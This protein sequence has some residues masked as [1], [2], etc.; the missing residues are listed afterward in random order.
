MKQL[1]KK[2][3]IVFIS[4]LMIV[5]AVPISVYAANYSVNYWEHSEP[6]RTLS[7]SGGSMM[8]GDDVRWYQCAMNSLII[9]GDV[10]NSYLNASKLNVDGYFGAASRTALIAFQTKY[11]LTVDGYFG[12]NSRNKIKGLLKPAP[13]TPSTPSSSVPKY[14]AVPKTIDEGIYYIRN[15]HSN[16]YLD[17]SGAGSSNNTKLIQHSFNGGRNQRFRIKYESTGFYKIIPMHS[18]DKCLDMQSQEAAN[19]NGTALQIYTSSNSYMEQN[20]RINVLSDG[21]VEIGS[22]VSYGNKVLEVVNS[23]CDN[24]ATVQLWEKSA[25][26]NNDNWYLEPANFYYCG[27]TNLDDEYESA[28]EPTIDAFLDLGYSASYKEL[29]TFDQIK[30]IAKTAEVLVFHGHGGP[31]SFYVNGTRN[32]YVDD[33]KEILPKETAAHISLV[34]FGSCQAANSCD[35]TGK[36]FLDVVVKQGVKCAI[37]F[38][39]NV[40]GSGQY[41]ADVMKT[42]EDHPDYTIEKAIQETNKQLKWSLRMYDS[43]SPS[44]P[45]NLVIKGDKNLRL[46]RKY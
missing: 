26:R 19:S 23:S 37:G 8:Y 35:S 41:I 9:Q 39:N 43:S 38:K 1:I 4:I 30:Q 21:S 17:V 15:K 42:I 5:T 10:N 28:I 12:P 24:S 44:N 14:S 27:N 11:G 31:S 34:Y 40:A 22:V 46:G 32:I 16:K 13:S 2:F 3:A 29:P 18:Q 7:Y 20:F 36:N 25:S 33:M 6:T 45:N